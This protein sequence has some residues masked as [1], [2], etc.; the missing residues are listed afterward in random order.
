M[1]EIRLDQLTKHFGRVQAVEDLDLEIP[2]GSFI[3]L[4]GPSGCGKTTTMNM[5]A[6][7]EKPTRGEIY[8]DD[9]PV[10]GLDPGFRNVGFVFQNYAI[11]THMTVYENL[12]FGLA[13][14]PKETRPAKAELD[15]EVR[16]VADV[17]GV[18]GVLERKAAVLSVN[19]MQKVALGRSMITRPAIFLLDEPFSNLDASFRAYMRAE[20]KHIQHDIGQTM[21]YVTHDQIEAMGMAD[22]IAVLDLGR[23]QQYGSPD[24]IYNRPA[25]RFVANFVGSVLIN[26]LPVRYEAANG[27]AT[28][29]I[30][31]A[32][33]SPLDV[34]ERKTAIES[35]PDPASG[36]TLAVRPER[37]RLVSPESAETTL[38]ASVALVE[39]LGSKNVVHL[40]YEDHE[41][42]AVA[43]ADVR[44]EVGAN[45]GLAIDPAAIHLFDDAS[46]LALR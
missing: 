9:Y 21:I 15:R 42:R 6:G 11:F 41:L 45:V 12:A 17:V 40:T 3:A 26:F 28:V 22:K 7:L 8:F 1:A 16:R 35:R 46:G 34:T 44:P 31:G 4:L 36:I 10:S 33:S 30:A 38:R 27:R 39:P 23:L 19:D 13:V 37:V 14:K 29:T 25:N 32:G 24:E 20:L 43:A 18:S 2:D 5:I